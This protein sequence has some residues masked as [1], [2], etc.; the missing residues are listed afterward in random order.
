MS[1]KPWEELKEFESNA[2]LELFIDGLSFNKIVPLKM[3]CDEMRL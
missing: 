2:V 1:G 3:F